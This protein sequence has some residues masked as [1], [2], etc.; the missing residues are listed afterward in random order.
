MFDRVPQT[1]FLPCVNLVLLIQ[2]DLLV[3][4]RFHAFYLF[5]SHLHISLFV[6]FCSLLVLI[7]RRDL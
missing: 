6:W 1:L 3:A 4:V 7:L 2:I 5:F